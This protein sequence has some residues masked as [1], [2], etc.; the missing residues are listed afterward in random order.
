MKG[1]FESINPNATL[2]NQLKTQNPEWWKLFVS[3]NE[4]YIDVRKDNYINIYY[5]GGCVAR[6][7]YSIDFTAKIH[8]KYLGNSTSS[9][10]NAKG[11]AVYEYSDLEL[12]SLRIETLS[13][14]K[15]R[16]KSEYLRNEGKE[17]CAEKWLQGKIVNDNPNIIDTEFQYNRDSDIG[18]L[19]FD[20]AELNQG[21]LT[22]IELKK[23][24][25]NRLLKDPNR[26]AD[27]PEII[28]QMKRYSQFIIKYEK[29]IIGYYEKMVGIKE[30]LGLKKIHNKN[31]KINL[32]PKLLI[33][34]TYKTEPN[35]RKD[36]INKIEQ[37]LTRHNID[38]SIE[39]MKPEV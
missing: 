22:F 35:I 17:N 6:I 31:L 7:N 30:S 13:K 32:I 39:K 5:Y 34:N 18:K 4:L 1:T 26:S 19:R 33:I 38:F 12:N 3:D 27:E 16:I 11:K 28:D 24:N 37:L 8:Q 23:I 21:I 9:R 20:L 15:T 10:V 25:D 14:I 2:F 36:R 29:E